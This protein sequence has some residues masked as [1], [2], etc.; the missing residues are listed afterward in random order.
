M[1]VMYH[2]CVAWYIDKGKLDLASNWM[3]LERFDW[4]SLEWPS[5]TRLAKKLM[6][7]KSRF[8]GGKLDLR[9][10]YDNSDRNIAFP[11]SSRIFL[12]QRKNIDILKQS[13]KRKIKLISEEDTVLRIKVKIEGSELFRGKC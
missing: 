9:K 13:L 1:S 2:S 10:K 3:C 6:G 8:W 12:K 4:T 11:L 5:N 7:N